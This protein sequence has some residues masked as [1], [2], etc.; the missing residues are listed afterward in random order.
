VSEPGVDKVTQKL[1]PGQVAVPA[2]TFVFT[3]PGSTP[4][5]LNGSIMAFRKL[6]Q[7]VPEFDNFVNSQAT[8]AKV[9]PELLGARLVGRWKSGEYDMSLTI[10][11][12]LTSW[13]NRRITCHKPR[14]RPRR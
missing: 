11:N 10:D 1:N 12:V 7:H 3:D 6:A 14:F 2:S 8:N 4:W 13:R 5:K 9:S